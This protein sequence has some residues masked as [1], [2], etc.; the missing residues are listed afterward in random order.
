MGKNAEAHRVALEAWNRR[1][2]DA[3]VSTLADNFTYENRAEGRTVTSRNEFKAWIEDWA[4]ALPDG[5]I[6]ETSYIE[7]DDVSVAICMMRGTNDGPF[8]AFPPTARKVQFPFCEIMRYDQAGRVLSGEIFF[9]LL[10][11]MVQLGHVQ[12]PTG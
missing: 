10:S 5:K 11:V 12:S 4:K 2:F 7:G 1:D 3:R 9:D 6:T 8:D